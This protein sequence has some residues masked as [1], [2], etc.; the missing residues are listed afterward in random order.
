[1][2]A[3][4]SRYF[5]II[6]MDIKLSKLSLHLPVRFQSALNVNFIVTSTV[7]VDNFSHTIDSNLD[8]YLGLDPSCDVS[9]VEIFAA[10]ICKVKY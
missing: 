8:I 6:F 9:E 7:R 1:M 10:K 4:S 2:D 5:S 3:T